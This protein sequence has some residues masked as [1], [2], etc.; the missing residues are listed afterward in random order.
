MLTQKLRERYSYD[1]DVKQWNDKYCGQY[2]GLIEQYLWTPSDL[3]R[4]FSHLKK[5]KTTNYKQESSHTFHQQ[6]KTVL[7]LN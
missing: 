5:S 6:W 3:Q 7:M 1:P 2:Y 4:E